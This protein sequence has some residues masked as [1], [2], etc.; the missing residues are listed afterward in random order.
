MI[1]RVPVQSASPVP[2]P[3]P[4]AMLVDAVEAARLAGVSRAAW[5][6]FHGRGLVPAPV[7]LGRRTLWRRGELAAWIAAGCPARERWATLKRA[8]HG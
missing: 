2:L 3:D 6:A 4:P 8:D 5:W 1:D 7:R